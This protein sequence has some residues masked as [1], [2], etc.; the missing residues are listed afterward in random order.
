MADHL[1]T[2]TI[3]LLADRS[4]APGE[5]LDAAHHLAACVDCREKVRQATSATKRAA[6][7]SEELRADDAIHLDYDQIESY[8][9]LKW[10]EVYRFEHTPHPVEFEMYYSV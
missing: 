8:I 5:L 1:S 4:L 9:E 10:Q 6:L 3:E 2:K 7:L